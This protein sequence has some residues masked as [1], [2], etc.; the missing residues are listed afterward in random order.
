[1]EAIRKDVVVVGL[2]E[3]G[4]VAPWR[5]AQQDAEVA[6]VER[7]GIGQ[8]LGSSHDATRLFRIACQEHPGLRPD[9]AEVPGAA[10]AAR[11]RNRPAAGPPE[12]LPECGAPQKS[13][14]QALQAV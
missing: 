9:R 8:E 4:S 3:F 6:G 13:L 1:M 5:L 12:R 11:R 7:H 14:I 10:D 2:G